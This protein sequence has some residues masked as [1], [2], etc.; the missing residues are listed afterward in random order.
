MWTFA[1]V[2]VIVALLQKVVFRHVKLHTNII[3]CIY[4]MQLII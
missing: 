3:C 4:M 2:T 1:P